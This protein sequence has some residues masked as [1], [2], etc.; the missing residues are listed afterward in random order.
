MLSSYWQERMDHCY[1]FSECLI[2]VTMKDWK[3]ILESHDTMVKKYFSPYFCI[4]NLESKLP[5]FLNILK[6]YVIV[7]NVC[8]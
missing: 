2:Q 6:I 7:N 1:G 3:I 5:F 8:K 4:L